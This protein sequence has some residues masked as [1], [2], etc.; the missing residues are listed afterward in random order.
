MPKAAILLVEDDE[1]LAE[2]LVWHLEREE[3]KV[4]RTANGEEALLLARESPRRL[5]GAAARVARGGSAS[6]R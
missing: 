5:F 6:V 3:F 2:L 1:A 4:D